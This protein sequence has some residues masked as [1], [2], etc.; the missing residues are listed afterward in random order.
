MTRPKTFPLL[1][2]ALACAALLVACDPDPEVD[3]SYDAHTR[4]EAP[5]ADEAFRARLSPVNAPTEMAPGAEEIVLVTVRNTS[6]AL[7]PALG[8][9]DGRYAITLR[10]RWLAPDGEKVV[11]DLDG[12][13]TLGRDLKPGEELSLP[14]RVRAPRQP[15][16]YLLEFDMVQEQVNFFRERGSEP[17]RV[18]VVVRGEGVEPASNRP[19]SNAPNASDPQATP[20]AGTRPSPA[21][22]AR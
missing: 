18:K 5:L 3:D 2:A 21:A 12:G 22:P 1:L 6:G 8:Q 15:G 4:T 11:D 10:N 9:E 7:W 14:I 16:E 20:G 19:A 17:A 13:T